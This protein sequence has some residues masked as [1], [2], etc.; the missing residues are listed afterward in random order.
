MKV[1]LLEVDLFY[2]LI[3]EYQFYRPLR[4]SRYQEG[5]TTSTLGGG[6][7]LHVYIP[8]LQDFFVKNIGK[9]NAYD[10]LT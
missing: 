9:F 6:A 3:S 1:T 2:F 7:W 4:F 8:L 10:F 5:G